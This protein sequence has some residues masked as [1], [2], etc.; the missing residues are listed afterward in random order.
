M[1]PALPDI[2]MQRVFFVALGL[3]SAAGLSACGDPRLTV[4]GY[5]RIE[6]PEADFRAAYEFPSDIRLDGDASTVTGTCQVRRMTSSGTHSYAAI[7]DLFGGGF[8]SVTVMGRTDGSS[9]SVDVQTNTTV[10]RSNESCEVEVSYVDDSG[11]VT[12]D[13]RDCGAMTADGLTAT[14]NAHLEL[15]GCSVVQA[16]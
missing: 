16:D 12:L 14:F 9:S 13:T 6:D 3:F 5:A 1:M 7:V 8:R 2:M 15:H 11:S 4:R 10:Y